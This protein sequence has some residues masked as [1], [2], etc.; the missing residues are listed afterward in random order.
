RGPTPALRSARHRARWEHP[1]A[2]EGRTSTR[3]TLAEDAKSAFVI[4]L[5][6]TPRW[7]GMIRDHVSVR[8]REARSPQA[9]RGRLENAVFEGRSPQERPKS[10]GTIRLRIVLRDLGRGREARAAEQAENPRPELR[11]AERLH[12]EVV[13]TVGEGLH[14]VLLR[15]VRGEE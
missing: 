5:P 3:T 8:S 6:K 4:R 9:S 7:E 1:T 10:R 14:D 11:R 2:A 12:H 13:R 15:S